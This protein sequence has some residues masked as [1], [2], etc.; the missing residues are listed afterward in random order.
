MIRSFLFG[1][2]G[3]SYVMIINR[4]HTEVLVLNQNLNFIWGSTVDEGLCIVGD[5]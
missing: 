1:L 4:S 5:P 3:C 2:I